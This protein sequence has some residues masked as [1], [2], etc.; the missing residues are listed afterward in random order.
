MAQVVAASTEGADPLTVDFGVYMPPNSPYMPLLSFGDSDREHEMVLVDTTHLRVEPRT[1]KSVFWT[2]HRYARP[3]TYTVTLKG[4]QLI[5]DRKQLAT[6]AFVV[7]TPFA[8]TPIH[9]R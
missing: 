4:R 8:G 9:G 5:D 1:V 2:R 7:P 6:L 3:G